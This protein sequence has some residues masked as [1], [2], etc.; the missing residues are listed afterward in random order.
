[1]GRPIP[2]LRGTLTHATAVELYRGHHGTA[3]GTCARCGRPSPCPARTSAASVIAAAGEDPGWYEGDLAP[4]TPTNSNH[5]VRSPGQLVTIST[6]AAQMRPERF[7]Y[8]V[9]GRD[10]LLAEGLFYDRGQ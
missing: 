4:P 5:M 6:E 9:D 2:T 3:P 7:G 8:P 1:M 10:A